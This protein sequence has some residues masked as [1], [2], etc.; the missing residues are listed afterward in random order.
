LLQQ[1]LQIGLG[2]GTL[3]LLACFLGFGQ[4]GSGCLAFLV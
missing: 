1:V 3:C 2:K 4:L